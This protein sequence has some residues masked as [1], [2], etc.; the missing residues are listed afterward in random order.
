MEP[1]ISS[2]DILIFNQGCPM[3]NIIPLPEYMVTPPARGLKGFHEMGQIGNT[4]IIGE[5]SM[6]PYILTHTSNAKCF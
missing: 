4:S 6:N 2:V 1:N 3:N 5:I